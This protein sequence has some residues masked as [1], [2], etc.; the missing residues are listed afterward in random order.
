[1][2]PL[3][4]AGDPYR[5]PLFR[6]TSLARLQDGGLGFSSDAEPDGVAD[7]DFAD[8]V[9]PWRKED[10]KSPSDRWGRT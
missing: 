1:M 8:M 7:V 5:S 9:P 4:A 6:P 2:R 3:I 10:E